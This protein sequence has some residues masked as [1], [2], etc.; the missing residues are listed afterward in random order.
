MMEGR[1]RAYPE[2]KDSGVEWLGKIPTAWVLSRL[3]YMA[4]IKNGQDYKT[5]ETN[6]GYPVLGSGGQFTFASTF[7]YDKES[8][9]LG[10]KGTIDKPLYID[11]PFWTVDTMYYTEIDNEI[12][13]KFLYY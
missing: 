8:V 13:P 5:V 1:Y 11:E 12:P 10:R 2:Y 3:K 6:T 4:H 7:L 9:L